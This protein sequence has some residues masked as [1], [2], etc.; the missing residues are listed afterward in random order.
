MPIGARDAQKD[1]ERARSALRARLQSRAGEIEEAALA[2]VSAISDPA[3]IS[4]PAYVEGL[5]RAIAAAVEYALEAVERGSGPEAPLPVAL[6][7]Q[8]RLA[9]RVGVGLDAVLRRYFA[10]YALVG[11]FLIEEAET[12]K[13]P[14]ERLREVLNANVGLFD[15]LAA[16]ISEEYAR[17][18]GKRPDTSARRQLELVRRLLDG[19][20]IE[21]G[22]LAYDLDAHHLGLLA[23][24]PDAERL[25]RSAAAPLDRQLLLVR[26]EE[27]VA[28]A[29]LGGRRPLDPAE[30]GAQ[31]RPAERSEATIAI[32]EP[33]EGQAGWRL[34]HR[35]AAAVLP[36]AHRRRERWVR[37]A[38][39]ALLAAALQNDLLATSLRR[40]YLEPL[41]AERDGGATAKEVLRA[42][43][44]AERNL[45]SSAAALGLSRPTVRARLRAVE[46]R[47]HRNLG[48][49]ALELNVALQLESLSDKDATALR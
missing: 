24:G 21:A 2:R 22:E 44:A 20:R 14:P 5:H 11:G 6:L 49:C 35:Q 45:S 9:A 47:I 43:F 13:L 34:T 33:A 23:E 31:L 10:G 29:W 17:E 1:G 7:A 39:F 32:G 25:L 37:Y 30:A 28:L 26:T 36:I 40:L 42:Y 48:E 27:G 41:E 12:L 19:E 8:A 38:D 3:E 18:T 4:D 16:A 46:E 15:R